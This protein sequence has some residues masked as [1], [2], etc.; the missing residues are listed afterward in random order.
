MSDFSSYPAISPSSFS[1]VFYLS[2]KKKNPS[3]QMHKLRIQLSLLYFSRPSQQMWSDII[4]NIFRIVLILPL[5][6]LSKTP[7][8]PARL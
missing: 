5:P 7:L 8:F 2:R 6:T 1:K 4:S 3:S